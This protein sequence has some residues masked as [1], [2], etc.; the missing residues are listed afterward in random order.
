MGAA[1]VSELVCTASNCAELTSMAAAELR[2]LVSTQVT[3]VAGR[4][5]TPSFWEVFIGHPRC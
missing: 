1:R 5:L 4:S 3:G 2:C